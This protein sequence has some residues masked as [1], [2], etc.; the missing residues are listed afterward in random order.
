MSKAEQIEAELELVRAGDSL[1][2]AEAVVE[3]ARE[4]PD[5]ALHKSFE[6]DDTKAAHEYRVW[7]ARRIIAIHVVQSDGVRK[8]VS[9]SVDRKNG[10]GYRDIREA[11]K[12]DELRQ[13]MLRD[14]LHDLKRVRD[15]YT[16][17]SEFS[18]V[19]REIDRAVSRYEPA[20]EAP[21]M[22]AAAQ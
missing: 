9:I 6:W 17:L 12:I 16:A 22:A 1:L 13:A 5:S 11:V 21:A 19:F 7:Q 14:A 3:W 8:F 18:D 2:R 20:H 10:G 4:H 15:R